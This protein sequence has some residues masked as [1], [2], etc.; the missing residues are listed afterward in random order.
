MEDAKSK[1]SD[2]VTLA[3]KGKGLA[4][5]ST[6]TTITNAIVNSHMEISIPAITSSPLPSVD[7]IKVTTR[8]VEILN[9]DGMD[10][11]G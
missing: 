1:L 6:S 3:V 11:I 10:P 8:T 2:L 9:F 4:E 5:S 7:P